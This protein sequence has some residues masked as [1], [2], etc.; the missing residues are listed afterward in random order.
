MEQVTIELYHVTS[1]PVN[2]APPAWDFLKPSY[3]NDPVFDRYMAGL[4]VACCS[5]TRRDNDLPLYST[6]PRFAFQGSEYWR[7]SV[8]RQSQWLEQFQLFHIQNTPTGQVHIV[9]VRTDE[10]CELALGNFMQR[11]PNFFVRVYPPDYGGF[12]P[13]GQANHYENDNRIVN[14][15]FIGPLALDNVIVTKVKKR[16]KVY[17]VQAEKVPQPLP[18]GVENQTLPAW[19]FWRLEWARWIVN[20]SY[21]DGDTPQDVQNAL[22][23]IEEAHDAFLDN[24]E[25]QDDNIDTEDK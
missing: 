8:K 13:G 18:I 14:I 11:F 9:A 16:G 1:I 2:D 6:Y 4:P 7:L 25:H 24:G 22:R 12:L 10:A 15:N 5:V 21:P 3:A 17:K 23:A 19:L 20:I